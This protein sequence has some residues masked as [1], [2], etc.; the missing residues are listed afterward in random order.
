MQTKE[1]NKGENTMDIFLNDKAG[2]APKQGVID[3][4]GYPAGYTSIA[5]LK[6]QIKNKCTTQSNCTWIWGDNAYERMDYGTIENFVTSCPVCN[7][8]YYSYRHDCEDFAREVKCRM[9][10][11]YL[12]GHA[13]LAVVFAKAYKANGQYMFSHA[14]NLYP[15]SDGQVYMAEPQH[16]DDLW[17]MPGVGSWF[18]RHV[19]EFRLYHVC[20]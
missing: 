4:P 2:E 3:V 19:A 14:L 20:F 17:Q 18:M 9:S 5:N 1:Q 10:G 7:R 13:A 11:D 12:C 6:T 15:C 16:D 8:P